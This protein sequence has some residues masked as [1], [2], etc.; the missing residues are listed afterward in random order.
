[1]SQNISLP[2][3]GPRIRLPL[4]VKMLVLL[5]PVTVV[6][7]LIV[8]TM[9]LQGGIDTVRQT[10]EQGL[11]MLA[12]TTGA[13]LDHLF[14]NA[15]RF[16]TVVGM[17]ETVV[18]ACSAPPEQRTELLPGVEQWLREMLVGNP[19]FALAYLAD[20]QGI[21][22]V[23]TSPN[24]VGRDYKKTRDY[25]RRA[26]E[27]E[28][29]ISDLAI[30]VTTREPG[31]FFSGPVRDQNRQIVG[32]VVLKLKGEV[33]DRVCVDMSTQINQG[34]V[35]VIDANEVIISHPDT[36]RLYHSISVLPPETL[37]QIDPTLQYGLERIES[38]GEDDLAKVLR[39]G[40]NLGSMMGIGADGLP[41]VVGYA[42]MVNRPWTVVV[43][44]SRAQFDQPMVELATTQ[45][46]FIVGMG[47]LAALGA[48]WITYRLIRPIKSL[49]AAAMKAADG[50]WSAQAAVLS[51][52]ELGDL[53]R[54]FNM[55]IP[56]LREHTRVQEDLRLANEVQR[57]TQQQAD[58]L[59][60][61]RE[62]LLIAEERIRQILDA[63]AEGIFGVDSDGRITFVNPSAC[64]LLGFSAEEMIGQPSHSLIHQHRPDGSEY[65]QE[66]C[67]MYA[68]YKRGMVSRI[69]DEFL[70]RKD[71]SGFPVEYGVR[72]I[73]KDG[74]ILGAVISFANITERK[75][76][77]QALASSE[78][79]IRRI[80]ETCNEGFW[81]IDNN[82]A[83]IEVNDSMCRILGRSRE[84]IVGQSIFDFTDEENL[85][86]F[87]ENIALRARGEA[88]AYEI[89]LSQP[90][91]NLVPCLVNATPLFDEKENKIGSFA[92]FSDI[93]ARK[94]QEEA[95]LQARKTAEEA[96]QMKSMFLANM[97][98]EIRT[99]MNAIIGLSYLA[100]K[101]DL[102]N[103]Q[104]D[105]VSKIHNAGTSLLG[106]INDILDFSKIEA[107]KLDIETTDF[108]LD[109][110]MNS[111]TTLTGQKAQE[112]GLEFLLDAPSSVPQ[113][114]L[115][116]PLRLGQIITNLVNNAVK[117]TER[118][119]IRLQVEL[120]KKTG[121][122]VNLKFSVR[123]TGVGMTREQAA[124]LFQPFM[125][126]DMSTTRKHGGTGLGLTIS[127]RLVEMMG[128]RIWLESEPGAGTTFLFTV[129]LGVGSATG[130]KD[131]VP[132]RLQ[133]LSVLVVDDNSAAREILVDTLSGITRR[134]DAVASGPEAVASVVQHAE[135]DPYD[136]VL[137]DWRMPGMD[138]L[139][140]TQIIRQNSQI[141][142]QPAIVI[143]T[144]FG[145]EEVREEAEKSHVDGFLLKPVT[146]ST[147]VDTLVSL[148]RSASD[149]GTGM[150]AVADQQEAI[151]AGMR[152]LLAE[153]NE[154]NQQIAVELLEGVG[155][156]VDI[157]NNG[158]ETVEKL[159][160][161]SFPPPYDLV[162]MD[163]QMPELDGY[164]ATAK[165]RDD[166][167]L[168][169][170]P[171][172]AMT[173]HA[174]IEE[175]QRTLQAGMIDHITKPIDPD[176]MFETILRWIK[177]NPGASPSRT[178]PLD[179]PPAHTEEKIPDLPEI[180]G[181]D[182]AA[183][184]KRV[185]GNRK[186]YL[187]LLRKYLEGQENAPDRISQ[188]LSAGDRQSAEILA[189]TAKGVSGNIGATAVQ[190]AAGELEH[191]IKHNEPAEQTQAALERFASAL[192]EFIGNLKP[193]LLAGSPEPEPSRDAQSVPS[194][195]GPI[196]RR[197]ADL[198]RENDSE[199]VDYME[200]VRADLRGTLTDNEHA[201]LEKA[202][203]MY[204]FAGALQC[205]TN[206]AERLNI[207][208]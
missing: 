143:V 58:E 139:Q 22:I 201:E 27:G 2:E 51:Y 122:K 127:M 1:M 30:G 146:K 48:V 202:L 29:F 52:D 140:A 145:R 204:D 152:I 88:G 203:S 195:I 50:D 178:Q 174:T 156:F 87:K 33:I 68:A 154:I 126:A 150:G 47:L 163:L 56:A 31:V 70:W 185:G 10:A 114:L 4:L 199:A 128:G 40:R 131:R 7:L 96:T 67:P 64:N 69:D 176:A 188:A 34:F 9:S 191:A 82:T 101:T 206:V 186:L 44:Q 6:P 11:H 84:N 75:R 76:N 15:Q 118:G 172:I 116:D 121:D 147:L 103:K 151:L 136:L 3:R 148:F 106:I 12:S 196:V 166:V 160:Q 159:Q 175:R 23:S 110:V 8:G 19:D 14:Q 155:A 111:V 117:F 108:L 179:V 125:Q 189:H 149:E 109:E 134:V 171:I 42:R 85:R 53:A 208:L 92:L 141:A 74:A 99:P 180:P 158:R 115:G 190:L 28:N 60:A 113:N 187:S 54:T 98:H 162:L 105:Y 198:A 63:A 132:E 35:M 62:S 102:D 41:Q 94:Q 91:G 183:A 80:L 86:I 93:T 71:G 65:P 144:A 18:R 170:L 77:E 138:G 21:C 72:P 119:E 124:K 193:A 95:L 16:Q 90:D 200:T 205:L 182:T 24:M 61:Q 37:A 20:A 57:Q 39:Q 38:A 104:R 123:D 5:L 184:L 83:T 25:M 89:A 167:R 46:W 181:L 79:K 194:D 197:L 173:A 142:Q 32:A 164:Q 168:K 133:D 177:V 107:G 192:S 157:A 137:M 161:G 17:T 13:R 97:S 59:R 43:G 130:P 73:F 45:N 100:L 26:L 81:L 78:R 153:D 66:E 120:L 129:W 207:A 135:S 169:D 165:I 49:R 36:T 55:M 112:K